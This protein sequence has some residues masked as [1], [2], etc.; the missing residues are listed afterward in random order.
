MNQV[1]CFAKFE[2]VLEQTTVTPAS[3]DPAL[4]NT[5]DNGKSVAGAPKHSNLNTCGDA[6]A[7]LLSTNGHPSI[8]AK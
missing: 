3:E 6:P 7:S 1:L 2:D 8:A 4:I 5:V